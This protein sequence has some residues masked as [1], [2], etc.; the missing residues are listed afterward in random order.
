MHDLSAIQGA[1]YVP[2]YASHATAAW[3][4]FR[5]DRV[6]FE[7]DLAGSIGFNSVRVWLS[8]EAYFEH[9][10]VFAR[11]FDRFLALCD[12]SR[13]TALP[14]LFDSCGVEPRDPSAPHQSVKER[15]RRFL[16]DPAYPPAIRGE[17]G[18]RLKAYAHELV[19]DVKC[20]ATG[21]ATA[22]AW[23]QWRSNPGYSRLGPDNYRQYHTYVDALVDSHRNDPRILGWDIMNEPWVTDIF[24]GDYDN[25]LPGAFARH[26]CEYVAE[27]R[28]GVP[29]T[30]GCGTLDR[31]L[32]LADCVD[33]LSFHCY[34]SGEALSE[35]LSRARAVSG[36][37]SRPVLVTE[38]L[39]AAFPPNGAAASD[40]GQLELYQHDLPIIEASRLGWFQFDLMVGCGPFSYA[41]LFY[42]N[43]LRRPAA[44]WLAA[45]HAQSAPQRVV[46]EVPMR[47]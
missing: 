16:Q 11:R 17:W 15:H 37:L 24:A 29:V 28:C 32:R 34:E 10:R 20:E 26:F 9:P 19:P 8:S 45:R 5:P 4:D 27:K 12:L 6:Q 38:C 31:A 25:P 7:L 42:P 46:L 30:V 41:G 35:T 43:G 1:N 21:N 39:A 36:E 40:A 44:Q 23:E 14:V 33:V 22:I 18:E 2:S 3:N 13:L 47:R